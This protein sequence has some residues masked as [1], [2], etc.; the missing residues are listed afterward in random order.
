MRCEV[1]L[2]IEELVLHG[3]APRDRH[4][5]AEAIQHE[6]TRLFG[7]ASVPSSFLQSG[8][9]PGLDGG[10]FQISHGA[11]AQSIGVEIGR[12]LYQSFGGGK[13]TR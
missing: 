9:S 5:I 3:F 7:D 6:L 8:E 2:Q 4:R 13:Q 1:E 11:T 10:A 12:A